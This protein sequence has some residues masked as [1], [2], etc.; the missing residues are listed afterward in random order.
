MKKLILATFALFAINAMAA[1]SGAMLFKKCSACHGMNAEKK[2][3]G[4]SE[5]I[6]TWD[7]KKIEEALNGYKAGTFG[8]AM[9]G[10]M[11]GQVAP[12]NKVQ[13]KA[14]AEYITTLK[15]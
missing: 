7:S 2:A 3:L 8:G 13:I 4:K 1:E 12:L 11:K 14:V 10:I 6:N 15:K 5:I 9:K